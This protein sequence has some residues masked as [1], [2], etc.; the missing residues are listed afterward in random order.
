MTNTFRSFMTANEYND[1]VGNNENMNCLIDDNE[2]LTYYHILFH[3]KGFDITTNI[4]NIDT[5]DTNSLISEYTQ[6]FYNDRDLCD[7]I[8]QKI[9]LGEF[10][11][12]DIQYHIISCY[13]TEYI[14]NAKE[15]INE[16]KNR[17]FVPIL[18]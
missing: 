12:F 1:F 8:Q 5:K 10:E 6:T 17:N 14:K 4:H 2:E 11:R 3:I 16:I 18:K 15:L 7:N 13:H 9:E